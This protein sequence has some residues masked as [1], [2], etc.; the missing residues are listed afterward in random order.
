[1]YNK[2]KH[3]VREVFFVETLDDKVSLV[4]R[5][6]MLR[7]FSLWKFVIWFSLGLINWNDNLITVS[8]L[9]IVQKK[10]II[11]NDNNDVLFTSFFKV[12]YNMLTLFFLPKRFTLLLFIV[13]LVRHTSVC[14][15][16]NIGHRKWY[17][18]SCLHSHNS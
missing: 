15:T 7:N 12:S 6:K 17:D 9:L 3:I 8:N 16:K 11:T 1:M 2:R 10:V 18:F 4:C 13:F 5:H 14:S